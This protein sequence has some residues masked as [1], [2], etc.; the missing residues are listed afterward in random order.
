MK[1]YLICILL[2]W[3]ALNAVKTN[4][5]DLLMPYHNQYSANYLGLRTTGMGAAGTG[6]MQK[7]E[8]AFYNPA[9]I[10]L[11]ENEFYLE[12]KGKMEIDD[13]DENVKYSQKY[14]PAEII[15]AV[16]YGYKPSKNLNFVFGFSNEN[17]IQYKSFLIKESPV[18]ILKKRP[19]FNNWRTSISSSYNFGKFSIGLGAYYDYYSIKENTMYVNGVHPTTN[20]EYYFAAIEKIG[21]NEGI[22]RIKP[23]IFWGNYN[24]GLGLTYMPEVKQDFKNNYKTFDVTLPAVLSVGASKQLDGI[25]FATSIDYTQYSSLNP[26]FDDQLTIKL[27]IEKKFKDFKLRAGL[28][29]SPEV[30]SGN[31]ELPFVNIESSNIQNNARYQTDIKT[32]EIKANNQ[33]LFTLG[34]TIDTAYGDFYFSVL[35]DA[36]GDTDVTQFSVGASVSIYKLSRLNHGKNK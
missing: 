32:S 23:G 18:S 7:S 30:Y 24:A 34:G 25:L 13:I 27:G 20:E 36:A 1:K 4:C 11:F 35:T 29:K 19:S 33:L 8:A 26:A 22:F 6:L 17:S 28:I 2:I 9:A 21:Y 15:G 3:Q 31:V 10:D 12:Y 14:V 16:L 5:P